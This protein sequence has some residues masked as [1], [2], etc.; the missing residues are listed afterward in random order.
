MKE[1]FNN[2]VS[3]SQKV[4]SKRVTAIF[5][6]INLIAL[7]YVGTFTSFITPQFMFDAL[8]IVAGGVLGSTVVEAF[9]NKNN[10]KKTDASDSEESV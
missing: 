10:V 4:S 2:L 7:S 6:V 5:I 3:Y 9:T 1:W 8:S